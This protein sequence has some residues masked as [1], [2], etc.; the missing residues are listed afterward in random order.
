LEDRT[1]PALVAA[2][3]FEEG[4][5]A[6]VADSSGNGLTGTISN[7][8]WVNNG[9][10]GKALSFNGTNAWVT[11][12]DSPLLHLTTG[13][14]LEA[15]V[16]PAAAATGW[17]NVMFK[18]RVGDGNYTLYSA[19]GAGGKP[20]AGVDI[21]GGI[22][23]SATSPLAVGAW[24]HLAATYNGS[25]VVMYVNGTQVGSAAATGSMATSTLPLRIGGDSV[26]GEY[27]NGLI[28]EVRIYDTALT[29][30][31][32][33][34][35]MNT[36]VVNNSPPT[37][38][39]TSP[40]A[41][42]TGVASS[43][44][45]TVT[46]NK[47]MD[48]TTINTTTIELRDATNT[49]VPAAVSY[50]APSLTATLH[51]TAALAASATYTARV[52]GGATDPRVKDL[53]GN[54][55]AAD[56]S[57]AFTTAPPAVLIGSEGYGYSAY[58]N[59]YEAINLVPGAAGVTTIR[60][61][62]HNAANLVTL[63]TGNTF[64]YYGTAYTSFYVSTN[65][66]I[67]FG[68][69]N[70]SAANTDLTSAPT[71]RV[72]APLWD[73]WV[74]TSGQAMLLGKY[75]DTNGDGTLDRLIVQWNNVQSYPS[76]PSAVTFQAILQLNTGAAPGAV[77]FNYPN[78]NSG[79]AAAN[80]GGATVGIKDSGTQ[81]ARRLLVSLNSATSPY[82]GSGQAIK[83]LPDATPPAVAV[84]APA[85]GASVTGT[86]AVT[87]SASDN[88]GVAGVQFLLD[89][90][91]LGAEVT[92]SPYSVT[93]NTTSATP[94]SH[95]LTARARDFV[96]NSTTSAAVTVTVPNTNAAQ[97][98]QWGP[99]MTWPL[100][101]MTSV[102][103][104]D[105]R[106]LM[107][108]GGPACIGWSSATV[109]DPATNTFT[110]VPVNNRNDTNDLFCSG[111]VTLADGRILAFGGHDCAGP[112]LGSQ[113]TNIFDPV[114]MQ[115]TVGPDMAYRRWYPTGTVLGDGRV[116]V[117]SGSD[118]TDTSYITTPEI[119]DP[120]SNTWAQLTNA[121]I[122]I[123]NY[124]FIF[125]LP[126]GRVLAA[127]SDEGAQPTRVLNVATQTWTMVDSRVLDAGSAVMYRPGKIIKAGSSYPVTTGPGDHN[128][129]AATAYVLDMTQPSPLWQQTA[130]LAD[131]RSNFNLTVLPDGNVFASGGSSTVWGHDPSTAV[132]PTEMWSPAAQ[133]WSTMASM[134]A[135]RLYHST[136]ILLPD[137]R[138]LSGGGGHNY[139][140]SYAEYTEQ[141]YSPPYL[142][143]GARPTIT[144]SP[145]TLAYGSGFFVGTP[146]GASI[147]SV[148]L[149]R[150]GSNTHFFDQEQRYVPL[151]F[152]QTA[153]GLTV[154]APPDANTAP[155]GYYMLFIVNSNGV[156]SVAPFVRLPAAYEDT[157]P[158]TAPTNLA[159]TGGIGTATLT[160]TAAT[161]NVGVTGYSVYRSATPNFTPTGANL[162]GQATTTTFFD[163]GL[164]G[165]TYYYRVTA[166]DAAGNVGPSSNEAPAVVTTD[167]TPPTVSITAPASGAVVSGTVTVSANA[168]DDVGVAGV[169]FFLDGN[170][171]GA[172]DTTFPYSV[173]WVT[174]QASNGPHTLTAR[175]RD[176][177]GNTT[178]SAGVGVTVSNSL[179]NGLVLALGFN[180]GTG[181]TTA[182][183]S[184]TGNNGTITG[185]TWTTA[186]K[187][188]K[189]L[190]FNGTS[191]WVTV[192][193][194]VSLDVT[195]G[196]TLEAWVNPAA[197]ATGWSAVMFKE[198]PGDG[199]YSLY[200]FDGANHPPATYVDIGGAA[201][202][203][204]AAAVLPLNTWTHLA[205]VYD[206]S[207]LLIYVNGT[208][209][210]SR[211][212]TGSI[213]TSGGVLRI[214]GDS[215][216]GEYFNGLIDEVRV[217]S[218]GLS[219]AEI[220]SD[221]NTPIGS[222]QL[223]AE[224]PVPGGSAPV[225]TAAE[226]VP[227][228]AEAVRRW[229]AVGL[230]A[231]QIAALGRTRFSIVN[232]GSTGELGLTSI[233]GSLVELDD[234][235]AGRGWFIDP[236]PGDDA[237]F[238]VGV[239]AT[240][241]RAAG[242]PAAGGYDLLTVVMHEMGHVLG[243]GDLDPAAVPHDLLTATLALGTRRL[244]APGSSVVVTGPDD[245][246]PVVTDGRVT[247]DQAPARPA[248]TTPPATVT[249]VW[250]SPTVEGVSFA[251]GQPAPA[252]RDPPTGAEVM[253]LAVAPTSDAAPPTGEYRSRFQFDG[254]AKP[255]GLGTEATIEGWELLDGIRVG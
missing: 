208:L 1:V 42:A 146:D 202:T 164:T 134:G 206:G 234:D 96:G 104:K 244:P 173:S 66:L 106:V 33:Q 192:A 7:A 102:L 240:E 224:G 241:A 174:A 83:F 8:T 63:P 82:V 108:D 77:T 250:L 203:A 161:D 248:D 28:D 210:F 201:Y 238:G 186:G 29:A 38:T 176:T 252:P 198:K 125:Q 59:P 35:D 60:S 199:V 46:F 220:Q 75:E 120:A 72:I 166:R 123:S 74:N 170:P 18:E 211:Q 209:I 47:A 58:T 23:A 160:W 143:K 242:G 93:W 111:Q 148:A 184:G 243:L 113:Y 167:T 97:V 87:A 64:K 76:S 51:P 107:W 215:L 130:S 233:G 254:A 115:W 189:A 55:L 147:A 11:V 228:A 79:N 105:G 172:E 101:D 121:S 78:L 219:A 204:A 41:G 61:S 22:L 245:G 181:T 187:Y 109:W 221:M 144:S 171:L 135:P 212:V 89:G 218:R 178:T 56:S 185:A 20:V 230:N 153:G 25:S 117:V 9:Q 196:M 216:F 237:E 54:A 141:L 99:V 149:I 145:A 152:T 86:V 162:V 193:D 155:P 36:P 188:G 136:A 129:A 251:S 10:F 15:W 68:S 30:A 175:A 85:G 43:A 158:P 131:A 139:V 24:A 253:P 32:I 182:D 154:Q 53:A 118:S 163:T 239:T 112:W 91:A 151:S 95:T 81:G 94:G 50:D 225:L 103:L 197:A 17:T 150:N 57:W 168:T 40:A 140:N 183:A 205:A 27:F 13:M 246:V 229:E 137:G 156:P 80:G 169:Q 110:A 45:V 217:Y 48:P 177:G 126:D 236:T 157:T 52:H 100:V 3:G 207:A 200:A 70:T 223:A 14:T 119:Y 5:G 132:Y 195:T 12:A 39:A 44:N 159:A 124:P 92:A 19:D 127:G 71:Q 16:K 232:L 190:S 227:I 133:T 67:S 222:P 88:T 34:A 84:T 122:N 31:Q 165:G 231:A 214:G 65:G 180:E 142:F 128:P 247:A 98:G 4:S 191:S 138:I 37:V 21:N 90:A 73:E 26:F 255:I 116:L 49:L 194:S 226:L 235:G 213:T 62:G 2:Y 249:A 6:T 69:S 179:P 114:T